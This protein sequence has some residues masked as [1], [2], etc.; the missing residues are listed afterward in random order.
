M[1]R[2]LRVKN[3]ALV[4]EMVWELEPGFT[5]I[6][7]ETGAGKSIVIGALGLLLG[8]RADKTLIRQGADSC[9][10]EGEWCL[11]H[12]PVSA[13]IAALLEESGTEPCEE[14]IL[15]LKRSFSIAGQSKQFVNGSPSSLGLLKKVGDG[16]ADF[17]GPHDHQSL[18]ST[19]TQLDLLD[20]FGGLD[21]PVASTAA[22]WKIWRATEKELRL[23]ETETK[24]TGQEIEMLAFQVS[25]IENAGL[26]L[27]EDAALSQQMDVAHHAKRLLELCSQLQ[28]WMED[29]EDSLLD[30]L[31]RME[32][33]LGELS[34]LDARGASFQNL[35]G[36]AH[37]SLQELS[38]ELSHYADGLDMDPAQAAR[39]E[40]R[41]NLIQSLK[42]KYGSS[43][44][45]V[46]ARCEE[47]RSRLNRLSCRDEELS[48]AAKKAVEA[49]KEFGRQSEL[50]RAGR[51]K[52]CEKLGKAVTA[53]LQELGFSKARFAVQLTAR[54]E[55]CQSGADSAEFVF[56]PNVG[57]GER[58]LRAI[59]SS[60]EMAR[61]M[62]AIKTA[63]AKQDRVPLL[64]FDEVDAN[65]GGEIGSKV[66]A[67]LLELGASHQVICITHLP[68]VAALGGAH[69][70]AKKSTRQQR[71]FTEFASLSPKDRVEE[72][73]RMLGGA[74]DASR[75]LA[76]TM[77]GKTRQSQ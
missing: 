52:A 20:R 57:E 46:I 65:I 61:V 71:T 21:A 70:V 75:G 35:L 12:S 11:D 77:L 5:V 1:L 18:L 44:E 39:T 22:A 76:K 36:D 33:A 32:R 31:G 24:A 43:L 38:R 47:G 14:G 50:L 66:G 23:L 26:Q 62:L 15:R 3:F 49:E 13:E 4:E 42:K 17:H 6:T 60:G 25:E 54:T 27:G 41:Y 51:R 58:P 55:P 59:A 68:Q 9:V 45:D 56:S 2:T 19:E 69:F 64:V 67:K 7:G 10:I 30:R 73:A 74:T 63:L 37:A 53:Q 40:E 29:G 72:I 8:D 16:L 28:A 34:Q 48:A